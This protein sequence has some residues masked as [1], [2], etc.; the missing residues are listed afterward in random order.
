MESFEEFLSSPFI[1]WIGW[2]VAIVLGIV[3]FLKGRK[4]K[5]L[6]YTVQSSSFVENYSQRIPNLEILYK[7]KQVQNLTISRL[8]LWN[9][10]TETV[11]GTDVADLDRLRIQISRD[12]LGE[13]L[14]IERAQVTNDATGLKCEL[15]PDENSCTLSFDFLDSNDGGV[16]KVAHTSSSSS[17]LVLNGTIK[18]AGSPE[19]YGFSRIENPS[20]VR[21]L[22]F[23]LAGV[24]IVMFFFLFAGIQRILATPTL[25]SSQWVAAMIGLVFF[26]V[27]V[28]ALLHARISVRILPKPLRASLD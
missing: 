2:L 15:R 26:P 3:L 8:F 7:G 6:A 21:N 11:L 19:Y 13:I 5:K 22:S 17:P 23:M 1:Q 27:L 24:T 9:D 14:S 4:Q 25:T 28:G 16:F 18:G 12:T 10:G 20:A